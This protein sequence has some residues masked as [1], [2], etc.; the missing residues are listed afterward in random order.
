LSSC[1]YSITYAFFL[2][3]VLILGE[4]GGPREGQVAV[5]RGGRGPGRG[6]AIGGGKTTPLPIL[7]SFPPSLP[8][9]LLSILRSHSLAI[10]AERSHSP[11]Q[12]SPPSLLP[13]SL[14]F[15]PPSLPIL[16]I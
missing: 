9:F 1:M 15:S 16:Y 8:S 4:G 14:P 6:R 2:F 10:E 5:W 3:V 13:P 11:T 12:P 7:P